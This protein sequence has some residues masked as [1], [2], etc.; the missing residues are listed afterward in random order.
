MIIGDLRR[1]SS[2]QLLNAYVHPPIFGR[3]V[4]L[5]L[6]LI[7]ILAS[8]ICMDLDHEKPGDAASY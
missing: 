6:F 3:D 8:V 7:G 5:Q 1:A 4:F 2:W